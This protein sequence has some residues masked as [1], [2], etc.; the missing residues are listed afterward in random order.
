VVEGENDSTC[1]EEATENKIRHPELVIAKLL[2]KKSDDA[3]IVERETDRLSLGC[4]VR[5]RALIP[6]FSYDDEG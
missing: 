5:G 3:E 2:R 1:R 6:N 4:W